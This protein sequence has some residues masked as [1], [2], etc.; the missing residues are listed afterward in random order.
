MFKVIR[1][2]GL[3]CLFSL[4]YGHL[5]DLWLV[6]LMVINA[7]I[8]FIL[9]LIRIEAKREKQ[10]N[11]LYIKANKKRDQLNDLEIKDKSTEILHG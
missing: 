3:F 2:A 6:C 11:K 4:A 10:K 1:F 7:I 5:S 9:H 8:Y